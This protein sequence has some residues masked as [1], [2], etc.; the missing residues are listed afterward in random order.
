MRISGADLIPSW[1]LFSAFLPQ[2][3]STNAAPMA[4]GVVLGALFVGIAVV[5]DSAYALAAGTVAP[6][7]H[8][9]GTQRIARRLAG[10]VFIGLGVFA[11]LAG[12]R[13]PK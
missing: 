5:T 2:F 8:A 6:K 1:P 12:T 7:L 11:A 9:N 13:G 10:S 4:Q 3:V